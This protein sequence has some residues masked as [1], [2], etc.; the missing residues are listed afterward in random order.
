MAKDKTP[1]YLYSWEY[2]KEFGE[3]EAYRLSYKSNRECAKLIK[4]TISEFCS[5]AKYG[6]HFDAAG[7]LTAVSK[8]FSFE[9][10]AYVLANT[11]R[12]K[13]WDAR[14]SKENRAWAV[15]ISVCVEEPDSFLKQA[16]NTFFVIDAHSVLTDA[17]V[18]ALRNKMNK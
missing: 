12:Q 1:V 16:A 9:R 5:P 4:D 15:S 17:L 6:T 2:A 14:F 11:I 13:D 3:E 7:A 10:I 18:T 8:T